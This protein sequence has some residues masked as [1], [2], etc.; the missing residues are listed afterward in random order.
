MVPHGV[1]VEK[2]KNAAG[3]E[4]VDL[5]WM[6]IIFM[7]KTLSTTKKVARRSQKETTKPPASTTKQITAR[8]FFQF[9]ATD[10]VSLFTSSSQSHCVR[11][12]R[13]HLL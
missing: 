8:R 4:P 10:A 3:N 2:S 13:R 5:L 1:L 9:L 12:I 11:L 6:N 7:S